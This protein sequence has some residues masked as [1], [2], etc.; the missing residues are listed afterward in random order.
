M[1]TAQSGA[2]IVTG[3]TSGLGK[4]IARRL[5]ADGWQV[6]IAGRDPARGRAVAAELGSGAR[7]VRAEAS[8]PPDLEALVAAART[9]GPL[10]AVV[11]AAGTGLKER[12]L[13]TTATDFERLWRTNVAGPLQLV[14]AA[15]HDLSEARGAVVLVSSDAGVDGEAD[16][17]AYSVTKAALNM[18]GR[19]LALDLGPAGV[20]VNVLCPGDIVPGMREMLRPGER[21]RDPEEHLAWPLPP[22][23]R[24]GEAEDVAALTAFLL[25]AD[26]SFMTGS[27]VLVDGGSRAGR[28]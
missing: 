11:A 19:M 8:H 4:A 6:V 14:Q 18:V 5:L 17:G 7:Y 12:L 1:S 15:R 27:V 21:A 22:L 9:M 24:H 3:G 23:G 13:A 2:A 25:S 16:I 26:A 28:T 10:R 20:R